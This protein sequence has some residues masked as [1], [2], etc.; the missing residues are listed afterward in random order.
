MTLSLSSIKEVHPRNPKALWN[1]LE[2]L[3]S[4]A[5]IMLVESERQQAEGFI[6]YV[7]HCLQRDFGGR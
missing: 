2:R 1:E 6:D 5:A 4:M 7:R 3:E